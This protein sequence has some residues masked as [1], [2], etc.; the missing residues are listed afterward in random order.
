MAAIRPQDRIDRLGAKTLTERLGTE[1]LGTER[2]G[3]EGLGTEAPGRSPA[4]RPE[5]AAA[6]VRVLRSLEPLAE[7][8]ARRP[9]RGLGAA[10]AFWA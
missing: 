9:A 7:D 5:D 2:L 4:Q 3:T 6:L 8:S 1:R 10:A